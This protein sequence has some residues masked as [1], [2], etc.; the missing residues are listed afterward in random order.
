VAAAADSAG[1]PVVHEVFAD[2]PHVW[3]LSYPAFP[4]AVDSVDKIGR[5]IASVTA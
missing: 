1:V 4:E 3:Q 2:M 5:F